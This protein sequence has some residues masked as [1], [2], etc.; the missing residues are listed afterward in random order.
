M[1][2]KDKFSHT[3]KWIEDSGL[4]SCEVTKFSWLAYVEGQAMFCLMCRQNDEHNLQNKSKSAQHRGTVQTEMM[5]QVSV[6]HNEKEERKKL[7]EEVLRRAFLAAYWLLK[8]EISLMKLLPLLKL[9]EKKWVLP[10][11]SAQK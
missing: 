1:G 9:V 4:S 3:C 7:G 5:M 6:F 11:F 10:S 2:K 8:E